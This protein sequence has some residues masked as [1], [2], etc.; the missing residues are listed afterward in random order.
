MSPPV[1]CG[2][3]HFH[4]L[5]K[6]RAA[7]REQSFNRRFTLLNSVQTINKIRHGRAESQLTAKARASE[8]PR[9][10]ARRWRRDGALSYIFAAGA[11]EANRVQKRKA[12]IAVPSL[13][14][15]PSVIDTL[16]AAVPKGE[17]DP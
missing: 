2:K 5:H 10:T 7:P 6:A 11:G 3:L 16:I 17:L 14:R 12:A 8:P 9:Q 1:P 4:S 15:L 13:D